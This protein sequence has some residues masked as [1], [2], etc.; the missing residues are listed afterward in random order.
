MLENNLD[1]ACKLTD[2]KMTLDTL[3]LRLA[4][5]TAETYLLQYLTNELLQVLGQPVLRYD[6]RP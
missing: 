4:P 5:M 2:Q 1:R 3:D 6:A